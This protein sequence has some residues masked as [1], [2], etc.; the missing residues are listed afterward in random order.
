MGDIY[1]QGQ[2]FKIAKVGGIEL[3]YTNWLLNINK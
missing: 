3:F 2:Q 1:Q